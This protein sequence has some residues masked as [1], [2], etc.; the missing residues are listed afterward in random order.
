MYKNFCRETVDGDGRLLAFSLH[1]P[2]NFNFGYDVV[3]AIA[4]TDPQRRALL[5]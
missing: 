2:D 3:D 1:Y 4:Q 5:W